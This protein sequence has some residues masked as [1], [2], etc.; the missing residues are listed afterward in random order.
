MILNQTFKSNKQQ[1]KKAKRFRLIKNNDEEYNPAINI[2]TISI[3]MFK[4]LPVE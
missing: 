3:S 2:A 4:L 1:Y